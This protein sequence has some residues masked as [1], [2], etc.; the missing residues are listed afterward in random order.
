MSGRDANPPI[1]IGHNNNFISGRVLK[2][3]SRRDCNID[4]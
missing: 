3:Q 2:I 1:D 4:T